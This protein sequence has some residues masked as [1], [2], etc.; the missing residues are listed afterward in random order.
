[1]LYI[2]AYLNI[3]LLLWPSGFCMNTINLF[4]FFFITLLI[5]SKGMVRFLVLLMIVTYTTNCS[6][7]KFR[8]GQYIMLFR[9]FLQT[10]LSAISIY[11]LM[12]M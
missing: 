5:I 6:M 3:V 8:R 9:N 7:Y 11:L 10:P 2:V 1:M 4:G 12:T